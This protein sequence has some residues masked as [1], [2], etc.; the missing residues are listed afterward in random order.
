MI[1]GSTCPDIA[2]SRLL[3]CFWESGKNIMCM[4]RSYADH[5]REMQSAGPSKQVFFQKW[6]T[7]YP[8][9]GLP[10]SCQPIAAKYTTAGAGHGDGQVLSHHPRGL[11]HGLCGGL[12]PELGHDHQKHEGEEVQGEAAL[13]SVKELHCLVSMFIPKRRS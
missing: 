7:T 9:K 10:S 2:A 13:D 5:T 8:P 3:S 11:S 6:S 4:D 1:P 12:C